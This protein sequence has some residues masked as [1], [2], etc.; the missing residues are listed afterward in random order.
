MP[1]LI[2]YQKESKMKNP[3]KTIL[4]GIPTLLIL[5]YLGISYLKPLQNQETEIE[6]TPKEK[7]KNCKIKSEFPPKFLNKYAFIIQEKEI[8]KVNSETCKNVKIATL[9]DENSKIKIVDLKKTSNNS[10]YIDLE[11]HQHYGLRKEYNSNL[12]EIKEINLI[13]ECYL[14]NSNLDKKT[15]KLIETACSETPKLQT[16]KELTERYEI[17]SNKNPEIFTNP[18]LTLLLTGDAMLARS[19]GD[20]IEKNENVFRNIEDEFKNSDFTVLNLETNLSTNQAQPLP[21]KAWTFN[22][23]IEAIPLMKSSG[24]DVINLAN[25]HTCDYGREGLISQIENL[26]NGDL[27]YFGA[28]NNR[29]EAFQARIIESKGVK[30]ALLGFNAIETIYSNAGKNQAGSAYFNKILT[31]EAI[32]NAQEKADIVIVSGHAGIEGQLKHNSYQEEYYKHFIDSGAD[33]VISHHPHVPQDYEEY[34]GK[35]I[36]YSLGNLT[37]E[38]GNRENYKKAYLAKVSIDPFSKEIAETELIDIRLENGI[39]KIQF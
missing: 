12:E 3:K 26:E 35:M 14:K 22:A 1:Y 32:K 20:R 24:I 38:T 37:F 17:P 4:L 10:V 19:I 2:S 25:N 27:I 29:E 34:Q 33:I 36:Y 9:K 16:L 39:P 21:Q 23:P 30:I 15:F 6:L 7:F 11:K 13:D 31:R 8:K 28:G 5:A 18:N